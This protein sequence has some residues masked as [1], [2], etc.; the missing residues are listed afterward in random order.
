ME[1]LNHLLELTK[2]G[3]LMP[4]KTEISF[5][6]PVG[7]QDARQSNLYETYKGVFI[8][9]Q[10]CVKCYVRRPILTRD[11]V[12]SV[13]FFI[14]YDADPIGA[15]VL[16][17][18]PVSFEITPDSLSSNRRDIIPNF[19]ITGRLDSSVW[20]LTEP[21]TGEFTIEHCASIIRSVDL[22]LVRIEGS[23]TETDKEYS[24]ESTEVQNIQ[25]GNGNLLRKTPIP[26]YM[27]FPKLFTCPTLITNRFR[28]GE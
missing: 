6:L 13:E 26:I 2:G 1:I 7:G 22:Q 4:G 19:K 3:C 23:G 14:E 18:H 10:Y 24:R 12:E 20:Q 9:I 5:Q 16:V 25:I 17:E 28:I 27:I 15:P 8:S 11:L 21:L